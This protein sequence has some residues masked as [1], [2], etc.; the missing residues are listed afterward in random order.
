MSF[1]IYKAAATRIWL[2]YLYPVYY[3]GWKSI[4]REWDFN[5]VY[6]WSLKIIAILTLRYTQSFGIPLLWSFLSHST[7]LHNCFNICWAVCDFAGDFIASLQFFLK[8]PFFQPPLFLYQMWGADLVGMCGLTAVMRQL[9]LGAQCGDP[10]PHPHCS[11]NASSPTLIE[12][13]AGV[14]LSLPCLML[15]VVKCELNYWKNI[16]NN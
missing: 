2:N 11:W 13:K 7:D 12:D 14:E 1:L 16:K 3:H 10:T 9:C 15:R 4:D 8:F 6:S 5:I